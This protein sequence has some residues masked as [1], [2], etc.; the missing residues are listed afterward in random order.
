MRNRPRP[1]RSRTKHSNGEPDL[2]L[3]SMAPEDFNVR[4]DEP[5]SIV[6]PGCRR[7]RRIMGETTLKIRRHSV[8]VEGVDYPVPCDGSNQVVIIDIDV[9]RWQAR[10]D[11]LLRDAMPAENRRAAR[12]FFKPLPPA[13]PPVHQFEAPVT[14]DTARQAYLAHRTPSRRTGLS[15]DERALRTGCTICTGGQHCLDG[16]ILARRYVALLKTEHLRRYARELIAREEIRTAGEEA[17]HRSA[18]R[19]RQWAAY[20]GEGIQ[21]ANNLCAPREPGSV[22]EFRGPHVP[23]EPLHVTS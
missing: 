4:P 3:S 6:C 8:E 15:K 5:K 21:T 19:R 14:L 1:R 23:L 18:R 17:A 10:Q 2:R 22:S 11:H 7:W 12:Q 16:G 20:G 9:R 13:A